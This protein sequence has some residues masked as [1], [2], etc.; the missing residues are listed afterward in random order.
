MT[1][2]VEVVND[3]RATCS[4]ESHDAALERLNYVKGHTITA[5]DF[6]TEQ[7][8]FLERLRRHNRFLHG[9]G[10]VCGL[11]VR[12]AD[13]SCEE[14]TI[15]P[16]YA[17]DSCGNEV[18]VGGRGHRCNLRTLCRL[19]TRICESRPVRGQRR[20]RLFLPAR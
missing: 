9:Y 16:G 14:I 20:C 3:R 17:I 10:V 15:D 12:C 6:E 4:C 18:W 13:G 11:L 8:Y 2:E 5:E 19:D 7:E 1:K